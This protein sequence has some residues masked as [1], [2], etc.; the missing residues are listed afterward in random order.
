MHQ[1][2]TLQ[3]IADR[4]FHFETE[5]DDLPKETLKGLIVIVILA[6]DCDFHSAC[7]PL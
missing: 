5:L 7:L 1:P 2:L 4:P 6:V 3:P